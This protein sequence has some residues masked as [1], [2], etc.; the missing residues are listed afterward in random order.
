MRV[1]AQPACG[2][3]VKTNKN[4]GYTHF[5]KWGGGLPFVNLHTP[6]NQLQLSQGNTESESAP[7]PSVD[8]GNSSSSFKGPRNQ[9]QLLQQT[10][11]SAPAAA[12]DL[13]ISP[14]CFSGPRNQLQL[15]LQ[16]EKHTAGV[17]AEA[18][19]ASSTCRG[20]TCHARRTLRNVRFTKGNPPPHFGK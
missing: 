9:L 5:P 20:D 4:A 14:S 6:W 16:R 18:C 2:L 1:V 13:G 12:V 15:A 19:Y 10:S 11:E 7:A 3:E 17:C 8:L